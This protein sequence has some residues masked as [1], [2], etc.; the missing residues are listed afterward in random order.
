MAPLMCLKGDEIVEDLLFEPI[1]NKPITSPTPEE[2]ATLLGEEQG[3]MEAPEATASLQE[4]LGTPEHKEPTK[5]MDIWGTPAPSK[6]HH[7]LSQKTKRSWQRID[8]PS[9]PT[10][11]QISPATGSGPTLGR[12][13]RY[14]T[15]G[16]NSSP[17]TTRV[18]SPSTTLK[19]KAYLTG[20]LWPSGCQL[21]NKKRAAG[22]ALC[23]A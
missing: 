6:P 11:T 19:S 13:G 15:G 20:R 18:P 21:P 12:V 23:P 7:D 1:S 22:G 5:W 4:C 2:E 17:F 10:L 8:P 14:P 3:P 16:G 9:P